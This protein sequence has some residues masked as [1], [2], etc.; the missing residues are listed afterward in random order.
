MPIP[1]N[2][3]GPY[4]SNKEPHN[5]WCGKLNEIGK[6]FG[7]DTT[8]CKTSVG[9]LDGAWRIKTLNLPKFEG[10]FPIVVAFEVVRSEGTSTKTFKGTLTNLIVPKPLLAVVCL[11]DESEKNLSK[12][13]ETAGQV[14]NSIGSTVQLVF[15]TGKDIDDLHEKVVGKTTA[16][17]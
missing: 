15:W 14:K 9:V 5:K 4:K 16:S 7:F 11:V 1:K 17:A 12:Y 6:K 13:Q 2:M 8:E 3:V 10:T